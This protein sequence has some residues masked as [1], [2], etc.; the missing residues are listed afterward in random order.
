[1]RKIEQMGPEVM[2][3]PDVSGKLMRNLLTLTS[4]TTPS[5]SIV[6]DEDISKMSPYGFENYLRHFP[7]G[8]SYM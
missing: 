5:A 3:S 8:S 6:S 2:P 7:A 4:A 1:M